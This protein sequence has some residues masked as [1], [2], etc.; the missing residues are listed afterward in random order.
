MFAHMSNPETQGNIKKYLLGLLTGAELETLERSLLTDDQLFEEVQIAE[1]ELVDDYLNGELS[2]DERDLFEKHFLVDP[3]SRNK[4]RL[5]RALD[6]HLSALPLKPSEKTLFR[7]F[8]FKHR[9]APY[10]IAAALLI[11]ISI[12]S[13][14]IFRS[15]QS[16]ISQSGKVIAIELTPGI[17]R[18]GGEIKRI[19][20]PSVDDSVQFDLRIA[21]ADQYQ[22]YRAVLYTPAGS[23]IFRSDNLPATVLNS[24]VS[25]RFRVAAGLVTRGDYY[26]KLS[27]LDSHGEYED[28]PRYSFR[29]TND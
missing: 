24:R 16:R 22:S 9:A 25:V 15:R 21:S 11:I 18:D 1:D 14:F 26:I 29:A 6:K 27:G 5:G 19:V 20:I 2:P 17:T 23:E 13:V 12:A 3:E 4:M 10:A 28:L 7:L 8:P